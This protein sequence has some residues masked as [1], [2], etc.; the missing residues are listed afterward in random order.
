M[1]HDESYLVWREGG[2]AG[3]RGGKKC[4]ASASGELDERVRG[5]LR[6]AASNLVAVTALLETC[7]G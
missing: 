5:W 6:F 4:A 7:S 1:V 3:P 2:G